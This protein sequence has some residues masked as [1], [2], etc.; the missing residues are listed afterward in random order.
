MPTIPELPN[1]TQT[2][3]QDEI[4]LSQGGITRA[5]T[6]AELLSGTQQLISI[7]SPSV[8][9][10][11]SLGPG[12]PEALNV[13]LGLA[14]QGAALTANGADHASFSQETSFGASDE[15]IV[16][17]AGLPRRLPLSALRALFAAGA[18]VSITTGGLI[19]SSTDPS[20][21]GS[22]TVLGQGVAVAQA[23]IAALGARIPAGGLAGLNAQGQV[24]A[25]VAGD[26]S[27]AT[28]TVSGH[29]V[30]RGLIARASDSANVLDF[31]ALSG[32]PDCS[33]AFGAAFASLAPG[34]GEIV[35]PAGDYWILSPL[36]CSGK[37]VAI[38]G[39]GKGQTRV[40]LSHTGIGFD[41]A[42]GNV[43]SKVVV[44]GLSLYAENAGGQTSAGIRITYPTISDLGYVSA[45]VT[46]LELFGYPNAANG[47]APFP[48]T[49]LRG[50][51]LNNCWSTQVSNVSWFGP[52]SAAG[53]TASAVVELNGSVDTRLHAIQ[54]YYGNSVVLQ[55]GYCEG[56][57]ISNPLVV[58]VDYLFR[59]TDETKWPG[60]AV[61]R[62]MLLGLWVAN[63]ELNTNLGTVQMVAVTDG[64]FANLDITRN[65]GP[66]T[67]QVFFDLT[68]VSNLHVSGCNFVGGPTGG[69][70]QD[71]AFQ[72][73]STYN[74]SSNMVN[75]CHFEDLATA[76]QIVG[77]NGTVGF[78]STG[79]H[80][81]NV[82]L[83]TAILDSTAQEG[84]NYLT[85]ITPSQVGV[86]A[87][88]GNTKDHLLTNAGG[89]PLFRVSNVT[90]AAN[91]IR[92]QPATASN[93]PTLCFDGTDGTV[94]GVI[95]TKGGSL[96]INAAGGAGGSGNIASLINTP[97]ATNWV[98]LQNASAGN[99]SLLST[100]AG[101]LSVQPKGALWLSPAGG[102]FAPGLPT[103]KPAAGSGQVWSNG[104][105][106]TI[107]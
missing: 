27:S 60:Y 41:F 48:Q 33:V 51:I 104:G 21:A 13:G 97:G 44:S 1:A 96:F 100:N 78:T 61:G 55:T 49:F 11:A 29:G 80:L 42:P 30:A 64:F 53:T 71:I 2:G 40:H 86:P 56:I 52:P 10:R 95:Q 19:S 16:N 6:V 75:D 23:G 7:G 106:L 12:G 79:L 38:R 82:P 4:P 105:V 25:P 22:L 67:T 72:F 68:N 35:I 88:L 81:G 50:I 9:G 5:V 85:F 84:G 8:L 54:A 73:K 37:P 101:G 99:L 15:A 98:V 70:S 17:A 90:G 36:V 43:L 92:H 24:T 57:Y 26:V 94:N 20:V 28:I 89:A 46:D 34:G 103:I 45:E 102:I 58:G 65:G 31:G 91:I 76:I 62:A 32:G 93:S 47:T 66:N 14:M 83:S 77:P 74:S 107:A 69:S 63:G 18:N 59:Q 87:G 3:A 39:A